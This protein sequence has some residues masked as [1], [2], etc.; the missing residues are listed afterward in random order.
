MRVRGHFRIEPSA[1]RLSGFSV[2]VLV[3]EVQC[4]MIPGFQG[5]PRNLFPCYITLS[6]YLYLRAMARPLPT[7][8]HGSVLVVFVGRRRTLSREACIYLQYAHWLWSFVCQ[9][10]AKTR[11]RWAIWPGRRKRKRATRQPTK[12]SPMTTFPLARASGHRDTIANSAP[13]LDKPDKPLPNQV[14]HRPH[15]KIWNGWKRS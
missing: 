12:F 7:G 5:P 3:P 6:A 2:M 15:Q 9:G 8:E 11:L 1:L 14:R 13:D 10:M 4:R